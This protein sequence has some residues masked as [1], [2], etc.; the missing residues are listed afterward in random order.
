MEASWYRSFEHDLWRKADLNLNPGSRPYQLGDLRHNHF[1]SLNMAFLIPKMGW[2]PGTLKMFTI[3]YMFIVLGMILARYHQCFVGEGLW[4]VHQGVLK[5][6]FLTRA[7]CSAVSGPAEPSQGTLGA[8]REKFQN[9][10]FSK[11]DWKESHG[12]S[13]MPC[14]VVLESLQPSWGGSCP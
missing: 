4:E 14:A 3:W 6:D 11:E 7:L 2:R 13:V 10:L 8:E 12:A 5:Q 1:T 9:S